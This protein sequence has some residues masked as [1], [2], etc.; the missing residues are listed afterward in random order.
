MNDLK[1]NTSSNHHARSGR[2]MLAALA[3][4]SAGCAAPLS[5]PAADVEAQPTTSEARTAAAA[6]PTATFRTAQ[7]PL[8]V[9]LPVAVIA[10]P[11]LVAQIIVTACSGGSMQYSVLVE[12]VG[13]DDAPPSTVLARTT[14]TQLSTPIPAIAAGGSAGFVGRMGGFAPGLYK[15]EVIADHGNLITE[16]DET[17]NT[18]SVVVT[19]T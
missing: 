3:I 15:L 17:N 6:L 13:V 14:I 9:A 10:A 11:D 5:D 2:A 18:A 8:A 16:V 7:R 1:P 12:N 19:C 4:A